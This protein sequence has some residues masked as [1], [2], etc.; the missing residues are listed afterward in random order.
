MADQKF[1]EQCGASLQQG[2]RFCEACGQAVL[3]SSGIPPGSSQEIRD[4]DMPFK[5][6]SELKSSPTSSKEMPSNTFAKVKKKGERSLALNFF[7]VALLVLVGLLALVGGIGWLLIQGNKE[8]ANISSDSLD[9]S[10]NLVVGGDFTGVLEGDIEGDGG[11]VDQ[12]GNAVWQMIGPVDQGI[13]LPLGTGLKEGKIRVQCRIFIPELTTT[14]E[15]LGGVRVRFRFIDRYQSSAVADKLLLSSKDWQVLE[16]EF[17]DTDSGP[18][19]LG[20]EVIG[21]TGALYLDDVA[22]HVVMV[23][24]QGQR[25]GLESTVIN[26]HTAV[27]SAGESDLEKWVSIQPWFKQLEKSMPEGVSLGIAESESEFSGWKG[28]IIREFHSQESGFDPDVAPL[29]GI[30][31]VSPDRSGVGWFDPVSDEWQPIE[32][33][34]ADRGL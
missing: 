12:G 8:S 14:D 13:V 2:T 17:E 11:P 10:F 20:I 19:Q 6:S 34:L 16:H 23:E 18:Y 7:L 33:F 22:A 28:F 15:Q 5:V 30:F 9:G 4:T 29:V 26:G 3:S 1:C 24:N 31:H 32:D 21:Y 25:G 27:K